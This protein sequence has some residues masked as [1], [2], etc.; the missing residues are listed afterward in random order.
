MIVNY[1]KGMIKSYFNEL[2]KDYTVN[3]ADENVLWAPAAG[4]AF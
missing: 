1:K 4:C 2:E 3:F